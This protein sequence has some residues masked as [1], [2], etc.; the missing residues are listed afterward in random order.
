MLRQAVY[1]SGKPW[2]IQ[3][4]KKNLLY[5]SLALLL[6]LGLTVL[7]AFLFRE[8]RFNHL[9]IV[10]GVGKVEFL[11]AIVFLPIYLSVLYPFL[12]KQFKIIGSFKVYIFLAITCLFIFYQLDFKNWWDTEGQV[13]SLKDAETRDVIEIG[14]FF[15]FIIS[16]LIS[17]IFLHMFRTKRRQITSAS[18]A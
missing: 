12:N 4:M 7:V 10:K 8:Y 3:L 16:V 17:I 2:F 9:S 15:Q 13:I 11:F 18:A 14:L 1:V 6:S 5:W